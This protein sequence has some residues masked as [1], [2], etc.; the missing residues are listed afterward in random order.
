MRKKVLCF[1]LRCLQI[2]HESRGIGM[3]V[4]SILENLESSNYDYIFYAYDKNNPIEQL[5]ISVNVNYTLVQTRTLKKSIDRPRDALQLAKVIWHRFTPLANHQ[6]DIFF[7][8]DFMLGLPR[9]KNIRKRVL[10]AYDLIPLIFHNDYI[11]SPR[12]AFSHTKGNVLLRAKKALRAAYYRLRYHLHYKNFSAADK[13]L[14]ISENTAASLASILGI[15]QQRIAIIPLA[16]VFNADT[17]VRPK[18]LPT[19]IK[20]FIF[21]IGATDARKQVCDLIRAFSL[22]R[23]HSNDVQL[24]LAGKEFKDPHKI[25]S[26][27]ITNCLTATAHSADILTLGFVS[28]AE[29]L[30]LYQNSLTFVFPTLYEGFGLPIVEAMK[31]GCPAI[32]Y[33]NSSIPEVAGEAAILVETGDIQGLATQIERLAVDNKYREKCITLGIEQAKRYTWNNYMKQFYKFI[34]GISTND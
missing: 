1:D 33:S 21:Y 9:L 4:R 13:I 17:P 15:P 27:S 2:G 19:A 10:I 30:W 18:G 5:G 20:P 14:S 16:P 11:P 28:D 8:F 12:F 25:P 24:V 7:Q 34:E 22:V 32:S 26:V 23:D 29:K 6:I 31:S 3:H